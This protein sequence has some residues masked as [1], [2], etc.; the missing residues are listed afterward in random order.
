M[1]NGQ[2]SFGINVSLQTEIGVPRVIHRNFGNINPK[3]WTITKDAFTDVSNIQQKG[4]CPGS[5]MKR[6]PFFGLRGRPVQGR[7]FS[8]KNCEY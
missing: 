6:I 4:V 7:T 1:K 2:I 8:Y 5:G 3:I